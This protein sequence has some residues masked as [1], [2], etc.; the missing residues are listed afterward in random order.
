MS[1]RLA[2]ASL[3]ACALGAGCG[4]SPPPEPERPRPSKLQRRPEP[5]LDTEAEPFVSKRFNLVVPLPDRR[6]FRVDET[7]T[8][9]R[10][11]HTPTGTTLRVRLFRPDFRP[12]RASCEAELRVRGV[13]P[14]RPD[15]VV[16]DEGPLSV[17]EGFDTHVQVTVFPGA[18]GQAL[19]GSLVAVGASSRSCFAYVLS[20]SAVSQEVLGVRLASMRQRS[21]EK[22]SVTSDLT[23]EIPRVPLSR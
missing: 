12:S 7:D 3:L 4:S 22:I 17:P 1:P 16:V 9:L 10:A 18:P 8:E 13:L 23:P 19:A 21:L 20:T 5:R 11:V 15:G 6:N 14:D 2:L